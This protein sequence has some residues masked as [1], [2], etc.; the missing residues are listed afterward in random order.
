MPSIIKKISKIFLSVI[1]RVLI[2]LGFFLCIV[3]PTMHSTSE[4]APR[5]FAVTGIIMILLG[6]FLWIIIAQW[7]R[8]NQ[9]A[10]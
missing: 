1:S 10:S 5:D 7:N 4:Q 6:I 3:A 9:Q 2:I 8:R